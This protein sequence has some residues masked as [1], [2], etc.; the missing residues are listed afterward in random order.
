[1]PPSMGS[2]STV[3]VAYTMILSLP[4]RLQMLSQIPCC[5]VLGAGYMKGKA[6]GNLLVSLVK[7]S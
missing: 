4:W 5:I 6:E 2:H 3:V 7:D 1:M